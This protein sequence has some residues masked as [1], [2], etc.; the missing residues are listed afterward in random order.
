[1][2]KVDLDELLTRAASAQRYR[3]ERALRPTGLTTAQYRCLCVIEQREAVSSAEISRLCDLSPPTVAVVIAN[4][5][6]DGH[7]ERMSHP[8]NRRVQNVV[9]TRKGATAARDARAR[10]TAVIDAAV[11]AAADGIDPE[12]VGKFLMR[13]AGSK[14]LETRDLR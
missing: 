8:A 12:P 2:K 4:L 11:G 13:L 7:V 5:E 6:R 3:V 10:V 14:E 1:M 9:L